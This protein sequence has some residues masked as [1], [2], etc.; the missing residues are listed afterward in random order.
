MAPK[1]TLTVEQK[2]ELLG[3]GLPLAEMESLQA[4]GFTYDDLQEVIAARDVN[5]HR[6]IVRSNA[7]HPQVSAFSYPEGDDKHPKG[8][9]DRE[10]YFLNAKQYAEQLTPQEIAAFN[11]LQESKVIRKPE[12]DWTV[13]VTPKRRLVFVPAANLDQ[14]MTLPNS[15][16][17]ILKELAEGSSAV[18]PVNMAK[19]I[20]ALKSRL[21]AAGA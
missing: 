1:E 13:E 18:D 19:E 16:V 8:D 14:L 5:A 21:E 9:L 17:L 3:S 12:G 20:Q 4:Q 10:T 7:R 15:L 2:K 11:A 6:G